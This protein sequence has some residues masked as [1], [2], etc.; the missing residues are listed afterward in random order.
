MT[1]GPLNE[2]STFRLDR[3]FTVKAGSDGTPVAIGGSP[4]RLWRLRPPAETVVAQLQ[5]GASLGTIMDGLAPNRRASARRFIELLVRRGI[6]HAVPIPDGT[7]RFDDVTIIIA[8]RDRAEPLGRLI[9]A[10]ETVRAR[11]AQLIVVDDGSSDN[12]SSVAAAG[13]AIVIT[14]TTSL[15][16]AAARNSG[17]S[18]ASARVL[19][20]LDSDVLPIAD[21]LDLCLFHLDADGVAAADLVA[22]RIVGLADVTTD[23]NASVVERYEHVRSALDLGP[24]PALIAP[25]TRVAYVPAAA[26]IVRAAPPWKRSR[27]FAGVATS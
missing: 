22:P 15:G 1:G 3:S 5:A 14:H 23:K 11:G 8:V 26:L 19:A 24:E 9:D 16:P 6:A 20:F 25:T 18:A 10:L 7:R 12:S 4:L 27:R 17:A 21:W 2:R 13:G